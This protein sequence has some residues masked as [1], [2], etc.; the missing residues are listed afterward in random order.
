MF[1]GPGGGGKS[2]RHWMWLWDIRF[3]YGTVKPL[4]L[5]RRAASGTAVNNTNE[6]NMGAL[7]EGQH[8]ARTDGVTGFGNT[9]TIQA[10]L[11][12]RN[13]LGRQ[14]AAFVKARLPEPFVEPDAA[15]AQFRTQGNQILSRRPMRAAAKGLSGSI[16]SFFF[17]GRASKLRGASSRRSRPCG[18]PLL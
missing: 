10:D 4:R 15:V 18:L 17:G 11:A 9:R 8:I 16:R 12:R 2:F 14:D 13:S 7:D 3:I 1:D 5:G 6:V